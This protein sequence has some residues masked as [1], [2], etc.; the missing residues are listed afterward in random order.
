MGYDV[1]NVEVSHV[2]LSYLKI[3]QYT[4]K[5]PHPQWQAKPTLQG[6]P[7]VIC[8]GTRKDCCFRR[9]TRDSQPFTA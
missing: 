9:E 7:S 8:G 3:R 2:S 1:E 4:Q 5:W 6:L